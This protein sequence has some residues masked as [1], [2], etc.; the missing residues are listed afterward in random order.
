MQG[1]RISMAENIR[2]ANVGEP[3]QAI[4]IEALI[5]GGPEDRIDIRIL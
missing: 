2:S 1:L 3:A 5:W 4:V